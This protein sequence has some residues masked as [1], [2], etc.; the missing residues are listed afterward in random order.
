MPRSTTRSITRRRAED[1]PTDAGVLT[2]SPSPP[3]VMTSAARRRE[4]TA[5]LLERRRCAAER[6][7]AAH[8]KH[9][10]EYYSKKRG[11]CLWLE[12]YGWRARQGGSGGTQSGQGAHYR[13]ASG[14]FARRWLP[15]MVT[16]RG[17]GAAGL[18]RR[19]HGRW[20]GNRRMAG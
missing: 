17:S 9:L 1:I 4:S 10:T 2:G 19:R 11:R 14:L 15:G 16:G 20:A 18:K 6:L 7:G 5:I 8:E 13:C 12:R 3:E